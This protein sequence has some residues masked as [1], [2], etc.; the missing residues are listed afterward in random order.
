VWL[1]LPDAEMNQTINFKYECRINFCPETRLEV[2]NLNMT[3]TIHPFASHIFQFNHSV[4]AQTFT[5]PNVEAQTFTLPEQS[6]PPYVSVT[7]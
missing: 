2:G 6:V 5:L 1:Y 4:E 7:R 3:V